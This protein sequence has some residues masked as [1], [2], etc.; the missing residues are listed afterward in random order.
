MYCLF[1]KKKAPSFKHCVHTEDNSVIQIDG[2]KQDRFYIVGQMWPRIV[3]QNAV[4]CHYKK[5]VY[6]SFKNM[7]KSKYLVAAARNQNRVHRQVKS[8][9]R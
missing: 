8:R 2:R 6:K 4:Q 3:N 7:A 5:M 1:L 9:L